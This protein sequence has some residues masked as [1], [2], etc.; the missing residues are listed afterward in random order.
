MA[1]YATQIDWKAEG[2]SI[3]TDGL[4]PATTALYARYKEA[5]ALANEAREAFKN[6]TIA[7]ARKAKLIASDETWAFSFNFG[8]VKVATIPLADVAPK[9]TKSQAISFA[10][11]R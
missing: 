10:R 4:T 3:D 1:R 7:D 2:R 11:K 9:A 8:Q 6:A 5:T